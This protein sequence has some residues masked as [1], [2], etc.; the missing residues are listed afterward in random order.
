MRV[1]AVLRVALGAGMSFVF[2]LTPPDNLPFALPHSLL[3]NFAR[4]RLESPHCAL[5]RVDERREGGEDEKTQKTNH[6][7][8]ERD[9]QVLED[10]NIIFS[11]IRHIRPDCVRKWREETG[12]L[13]LHG[14]PS[15]PPKTPRQD[16]HAIAHRIDGLENA[17]RSLGILDSLA[18][19]LTRGFTSMDVIA[20]IKPDFIAKCCQLSMSTSHAAHPI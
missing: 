14:I 18:A 4:S 6:H 1:A 12:M 19:F 17:L 10:S 7:E 16:M 5:R 9:N 13:L 20:R 15:N 3:F 2:V 11:Q 8:T